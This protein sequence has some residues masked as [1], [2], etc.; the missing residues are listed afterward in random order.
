MFI[1]NFCRHLVK[2]FSHPNGCQSRHQLSQK[3]IVA[4]LVA[5]IFL[6]GVVT[7][8]V[9]WILLHKNPL[10]D[11]DHVSPGHIFPVQPDGVSIEL[12]AVLSNVSPAVQSNPTEL[13]FNCMVFQATNLK[14]QLLD[15][16][17]LKVRNT[18]QG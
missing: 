16:F 9:R 11:V 17:P 4:F 8:S 1:K 2:V 18:V 15:T 14:K 3:L 10:A 6:V 5:E 13:N 7:A 12:Q